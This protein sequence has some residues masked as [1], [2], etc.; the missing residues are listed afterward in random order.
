MAQRKGA[1]LAALPRLL[2]FTDPQRSSDLAALAARLPPDAALVYRPFGAPDAEAVGRRLLALV[3]A[4]RG[5]LLI[6]QDARLAARLGADGVH[7]PERSAGRARALKTARPGWIVTAAAHSPRAA[8][9]A[10][11]AGVDA[12]VISA[13]F[14]S[15][16]ASAGAPLGPLGLA[17]IVRIAGVP[18]YALGGVNDRTAGR[19][20]DI[21][22]AG[23]A[24]VEGF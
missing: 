23:L 8:R 1:R 3:R 5:R 20:K 18:A 11:A 16:S 2:V 9:N 10:R 6:G 22:L 13:V 15:R 19:L 12:V 17:R 21:R 24:A 14:P 4:R 7:L